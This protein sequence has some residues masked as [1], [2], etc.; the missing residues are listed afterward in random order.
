MT[1]FIFIAV[2]GCSTREQKESEAEENDLYDGPDKAMEFEWER[3]HELSSGKVPMAKLLMAIQETESVKTSLRNSPT[4]VASLGWTER[5]PNGDFSGPQGNSRPNLDQTA[6]RIRA[7]MVDSTDPTHKTVWAGG[8]DGG[9]WKTTDIT[10]SPATWILINDFMSNLAISAICQDP[11]PGFQNILYVCTGE[12][13]RNAD[14]V[15]GVGVFKSTDGGA[16]WNY[17]ASTSGYPLCT[18]ILCDYQGNVYLATRNTG[19]LRSSDGG[20]TWTV[21]TP[22]GVSASI[23]DLEISSTSGPAR[24]HMTTGIG[25]TQTY[26]YTDNPATVTSGSGWNAA[27]TPF[28]SYNER[29]EMACS[30]NVLYAL[31][32]D[33]STYNVPTIYKSTDGGVNWNPTNSQPG[34]G[35]WANGQGWYS[36]SAGINPANSNE[37]ICGGLDCYK[38]TDGGGSW[39]KISTWVGSSGQYVHADQHNIQWWD[40]GNKLLFACDGGIHFSSNGGTT[41]RDRNKGL[42]LKQFYSIALHPNYPNY[43]L[44][45]AQDNGVHRL[46]HPGLDSSI[47]VYGG[48][49]CYVA[50]DQDQPQY[51]FGSYVYNVYRRSTN[52]GATWSTPVSDQSSGRFVN[53]WD[54]DN[55]A[56]IIY[57]CY[58][59]N[60]FLRWNNPQ[61]GTS[62]TVVSMPAFAGGNVSAVHA[63]PYLLNRVYFGTG[64]GGIIRVD[65]ANGAS[66]TGTM[67][68]SG[69]GMPAGYV[70]C[71]VTGSS[72]QN[73]IACFTNYGVMNVWVTNDGGTT[74]TGIDGNLPDMPVRWALFHPDT[75]TK[76][77]IA[78]ETGVW[79]TD[80]I[81]GASTVWTPNSTFPTVRTDM[82]KYRSSDRTIAAG[83]H[84]RGIWTAVIPAAASF[85]LTTPAPVS[86]NCP[87]PA[88]MDITL[89]TI[90]NGGFSNPI[91]L[92][93]TGNPGGTTVSFS[94]NPVIP[95]NNTIVTL[96]GT[97]TLAPGNYVIA[98]TGTA[99]GSPPVTRNLTYIINPGTGPA[100]T[101]HPNSQ[102]ICAGS[103]A[104]FAISSAQATSFQW[105]LS[106]DGGTTWNN[107]GGATLSSYTVTGA[108]AGMNGYR[109]RC[110]ATNICG[111]NAS[112]A[113]ILTVNTAPSFTGQPSDAS[114]CTG[115]GT[116]FSVSATGSNIT[117]QWQLSTDGGSTWNNIGGATLSSYTVSGAT[118]G[119][120]GYRYRCMLTGVCPPSPIY[121][122]G[123][124]LT[125][126]DAASITGQPAD[127]VVCAG[128]NA[129]FTVTASGTSVNYQWQLST[130]GGATWNNIGGATNPTYTITGTT[131]GMNGYRYRCIVGNACGNLTSTVVLLTVNSLPAI[132]A[133]PQDITLCAGANNTFSVTASGT[134][135]G[136]Q[137][138]LST[139]G[140]ATYNNIPGANTT[141]Y[142]VSGITAGMNGYK[143]RCVVTG[144]CNPPVTSNAATL[145]VV[146]SVTITSQPADQTVCAGANTSFTVA[147]SGTGI[148]YQWQLSTDGGA[149][150]NNI[151]GANAATYN[152][153]GA[154]AGMNGYKYRC[155]LSNAT[156]TTP[157]I[158]NPA[159]LTVNTGPSI[160]AQPSDATVCA[161]NNNQFCVTASGTGPITYQWQTAPSCAGPWTNI[162][163]PAA[164]NPCYTATN[165]PGTFYY[166]CVVTNTCGTVNSNCATF[167]VLPALQ[168]TTQPADIT[169]CAGSNANF[170]VTATGASI[171]YQWQ[172]STDGGVT[173]NNIGGATNPAYTAASV[174]AGMN[175]YRFRCVLSS[176]CG[177]Q[178]SNAAIL[179]VNTLPAIT[180]SPQDVTLCAGSGNTF[181]VSA[182][183]SGIGYQW[184]LSTD[185]GAT[186]NNIAGATS[187]SYTV[188]GVTAGMNG[189]RYRCVVTGLCPP[190][191]TSGAAIL[192]VI[193]AVSITSQPANASVCAGGNTGFS[194]AGSSVQTILYQWQLST[195][196]GATW[197]NIAGAT[198]ANYNISGATL[199]MNN[200]RYRCLLSSA[201][202]TVPTVSNAAVLTVNALPGVTW[203][204]T[205]NDQCSNNASYTLTGGTPAGGTYS[206]TGVTGTNFNASVAGVGTFTLTYT[207]TNANGCTSSA[208]NTIRVRQQPAIGLTAAP[209]TSL[210]PGQTTMLTA[211][212]SASTGG[213]I[214]T[215]WTFNSNPLSVTG[216]SYV[217]NVEKIGSYQARVLETW[218]GGLVCSN[219]S[220]VVTITALPSNKL[221]IFPSPNDGRFTISY[222]NNGG[223]N[224]SRTVVVLDSKGA[225]VYESKF[226]ITGPYTLLSV[227]LRPAARGVYY[228][229]IYDAA[230]KRLAE[231]KVMVNW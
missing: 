184:Q 172:L 165:T 109:Y 72:D 43:F 27:A 79:E 97:N 92:S 138:Q 190:S 90:S 69:A 180:A 39:T 107:I 103:N 49:G 70:N 222:Y 98:V 127:Q 22:S 192:T 66:P 37:F 21:I 5:G 25:T 225:R 110:V 229:I 73:L 1:A 179:T 101:E 130:D 17:L 156:C 220:A 227:D 213:V 203:T 166:R 200:N 162:A 20:S 94:A 124:I 14:A 8:V 24:L 45:G 13:F 148:L 119:M 32:C 12:S 199:A 64:I 171:T 61:T 11:R 41:I 104:T 44:A 169:V 182:T 105:Q 207:Y 173:W 168:I 123:A 88:S 209:L 175:G 106:T 163:G 158:S 112:N 122:N 62:T 46:N 140:G 67:I 137:W 89:G 93:A 126:V 28:P 125:V 36:L 177:N 221:F 33:P 191:A 139:D 159:T 31:P 118:A 128:S 53:P 108:T 197:N 71:V 4:T 18:R 178:T 55:N 187:S 217:V 116:S 228:A 115:G 230:G 143:Y 74:W 82:I 201:T 193:S 78:T 188:S 153:T 95:G 167:T 96:N 83:T 132:S 146:T 120:N 210:L 205:L 151:A 202:C 23:C 195:D 198:T 30:G 75:D 194:V 65:N 19:L 176:A 51:Q 133:H 208:T 150:W 231:G 224:T 50:I 136:Y 131:T 56:N 211:T 117:Y 86:T 142:T 85:D 111:N 100:I 7:A 196:G 144:T 58:N 15:R 157:G 113:A 152:I 80:L 34:G 77:Y 91:T 170:S 59:A 135:I 29:A 87:A 141:S 16:N 10:A 114:V 160:T 186:W 226:S 48:D 3:T 149:T 68:N 212:P 204:N 189:Y 218:P 147:G 223:S 42:R 214:S 38:T 164:L 206:G 57:A 219:Q 63:S 216:N 84:G 145:T 47:E 185:G 60:N 76:A 26:R 155:Q 40:G 181:N 2:T 129:S 154:T 174:T 52:N 81:N 134:G 6:G 121:S 183:G 54:Y 102:T 161:G 9:L 99:T 35:T 215:A